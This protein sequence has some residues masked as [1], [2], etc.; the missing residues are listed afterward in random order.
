MRHAVKRTLV[1]VGVALILGGA[2]LL[3]IAGGPAFFVVQLGVV[4]L[5]VGVVMP[6]HTSAFPPTYPKDVR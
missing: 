4:L 2:A 1:A 5:L 3:L 6:R